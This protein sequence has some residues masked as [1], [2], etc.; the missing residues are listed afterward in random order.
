MNMESRF[1]ENNVI[2]RFRYDSD[3]TSTHHVKLS[4]SIPKRSAASFLSQADFAGRSACKNTY[5]IIVSFFSLAIQQTWLERLPWSVL[6][7]D[8]VQS[9]YYLY[10]EDGSAVPLY[11]LCV[12]SS[13]SVIF[14]QHD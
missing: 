10:A 6:R 14:L 5:I 11:I 8:Y 1:K 3:A 13:W 7:F 9:F 4:R 12:M 2:L